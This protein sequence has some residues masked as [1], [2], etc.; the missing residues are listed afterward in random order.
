MNVIAAS[1][2]K[3]LAS[4]FSRGWNAAPEVASAVSETVIAVREKGDATLVEYA[5]RYDDPSFDVSK[6]RVPLPMYDSARALVPHETAAALELAR[7]RIARFHERQRQVDL[8]YAEEDGTRY[9]LQRRPLDSVAVY[10]P[11]STTCS[12]VAVLMGAVPA[13]IAGVNRTIVLTPP[14]R[15][16]H[17]H[18]A[19]IFACAICGV[20][21][22]YAVG[23]AHA[24]AAAAFGTESIAPVDKI[25]GSGGVWVTEAKRQVFGRCG[26]DTLAGPAEV[27]VV[28]DDAANS[29]Y[30]AGELLAQAEQIATSRLAVV[31]E[32]RPLLDAVAQL[33][34]TLGLETLERGDAIAA[35]IERGCVLIHAASREEVFDVV[36]RFAPAYLCLQVRD[37]PA[38]L[39]RIRRAGT[40]FVG[41]LTPLAAGEYVAGTNH[42]VPTSGT[43]RWA[44]SLGLEDFMRT[45]NVVENT[46]ERMMN[47]ALAIATLAELEG[48]PQ[49]AQTARMRYGG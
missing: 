10:A 8:S 35:A 38:Y 3:R 49:H 12:P 13:K 29:E 18:P 45:I 31:S 23:G 22:L 34:D 28:A 42:V 1:E 5:R 36:D 46:A 26:I 44:S 6:L 20:D 9:A 25:V 39:P 47:D 2:T 37:A 30:V 19:V 32:S 33:L 14:R 43:A 24:I 17:V 15:N 11:G 21:E 4:V 7:D 41:D 48:L 16:G 40:I 27:L